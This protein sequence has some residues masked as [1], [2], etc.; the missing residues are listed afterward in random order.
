MR[1]ESHRIPH[2]TIGNVWNHRANTVF[3]LAD[4]GFL[5]CLPTDAQIADA[6]AAFQPEDIELRLFKEGRR[7]AGTSFS[8]D[9]D[10]RLSVLFRETQATLRAAGFVLYGAHTSKEHTFA[11]VSV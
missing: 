3:E 1:D 6:L 5:D 7:R 11:A 4:P 2:A 8:A 10:A 9:P